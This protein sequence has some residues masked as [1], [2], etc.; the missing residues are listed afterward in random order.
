M[1]FIFIVLF[2]DIKFVKSNDVKLWRPVNASAIKVTFEISK[3]IFINL[4]NL[5]H[6]LNILYI[7]V[8]LEVSKLSKSKLIKFE[9][10]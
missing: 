9:Q 4:F 2:D 1:S 10:K 6:P 5:T 7:L 3:L 8:I